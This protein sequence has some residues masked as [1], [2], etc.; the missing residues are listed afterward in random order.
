MPTL[1]ALQKARQEMTDSLIIVYASR[2]E[3][4]IPELR[5]ETN[6]AVEIIGQSEALFKERPSRFFV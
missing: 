2:E 6:G 3:K 4:A 1:P 5:R